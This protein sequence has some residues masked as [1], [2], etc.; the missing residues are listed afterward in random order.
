MS[1]EIFSKKKLQELSDNTR[2]IFWEKFDLCTGSFRIISNA[3][4]LES[5]Q[6]TA[7]DD[8][9]Q[10]FYY[11]LFVE[12]Q[13]SKVKMFITCTKDKYTLPGAFVQLQYDFLDKELQSISVV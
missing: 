7:F 9:Y 12:C 2:K 6:F 11:V 10:Q 13:S 3:T 1:N 5:F 4:V 8:R